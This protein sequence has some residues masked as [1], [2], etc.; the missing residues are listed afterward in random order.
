VFSVFHQRDQSKLSASSDI[1]WFSRID[2]G[3]GGPR[4][5]N[6]DARSCRAPGVAEP[7]VDHGGPARARLVS[8]HDPRRLEPASILRRRSEVLRRAVMA[9]PRLAQQS[10]RMS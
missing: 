3:V 4:H 2:V 5:A 9:P 7:G 8:A 1:C 10:G 6:S